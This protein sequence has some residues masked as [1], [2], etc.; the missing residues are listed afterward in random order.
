MDNRCIDCKKGIT[1]LAKRCRDCN[2]RRPMSEETKEKISRILLKMSGNRRFCGRWKYIYKVCRSHPF[3]DS[4]GYV[5]E[6]RL[7]ME[8]KLGRYLKKSEVVHHIDGDRY[9]NKEWNL[10]VFASSSDHTKFHNIVE[11][12]KDDDF[13]E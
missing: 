1:V 2:K 12:F 13:C 6:H 5:A 11:G 4:K 9:N 7:V 8:E 3:K 10:C